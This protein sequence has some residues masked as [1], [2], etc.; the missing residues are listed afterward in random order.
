MAFLPPPPPTPVEA[1]LRRERLLYLAGPALVVLL[2][3]AWLVPAALDMYGEMSGLSAWMM[4]AHWDFRYGLLIFL[5][6]SVMMAG[7]MLPSLAPALLLYGGIC[8]SDRSGGSP[9]LRVNSFAAGYLLAWTGFSLAA[10]LLQWQLFEQGLLNMMMELGNPKLAAA[11]LVLA[12]L[13]QWTPLKQTC[14]SRCRSPA[15]FISE[16]WRRGATGGLLLGLHYG[17]YCLG[18]CWALMLMLFVCGVMNLAT[19]ALLT[20]LVFLEKSARWGAA[21]AKGLGLAMLAAGLYGLGN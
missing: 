4:A 17:L 9:A 1:L 20:A 2:A 10:T 8:R 11:A 7:M 5:M 14:L 15:G 18:C 13:F 3:W 6:W 21:A 12:G 19:I 16:H